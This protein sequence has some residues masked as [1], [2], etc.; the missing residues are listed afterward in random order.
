MDN[1]SPEMLEPQRLLRKG[2]C[3]DLAVRTWIFL[4]AESYPS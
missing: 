1:Q 3:L 4:S 2:V